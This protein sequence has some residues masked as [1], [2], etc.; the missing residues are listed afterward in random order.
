MSKQIAIIGAGLSGLLA[1]KYAMEKGFS[2]IVFE[3]KNGLGGVWSQTLKPTKLQTP[4]DYYQFSDFPWPDSVTGDFPHSNQVKDY[5]HSYA[6]HFNILPQIKFN[7]RVVDIDYVTPY[8]DHLHSWTCWGGTGEAFSAYG[9]WVV[10]VENHSAGP[11]PKTETYQVDFVVL[12]LGNFSDL[13]HIPDFPVNKGPEVF[14]GKVLHSM[15]YSAMDNDKAAEFINCK[16]VT[17]VGFQKS[18]I[19]IAAEVSTQNG[20]KHPCTLLFRRAHWVVPEL[21]LKLSFKYQNRFTEFM[22]HKPHEGFFLWLLSFLLY[23]LIWL[24]AVLFETVVKLKYP[25][26]RYKTIPDQNFI[27]QVSSCKAKVMPANFYKNA[28]EGSLIFKKAE[29]FHFCKNGLK[30]EGEKEPIETDIVIFATGYRTDDKLKSIFK[31]TYFQKRF[32]DSSAPFYRECIHPRIPQLAILGYSATPATLYTC[33]M[34]A[35]WLSHFLAGRFKL[36]AIKEMQADMM[37]W[38]KST[39]TFAKEDYKRA[40]VTAL[41]QIHNNDQLCKDMGVNPK[42]KS[43]FMPELFAPYTPADY[44]N[45]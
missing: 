40:C 35:R 3:A 11:L 21:L 18:A 32:V 20:V 42:R 4:R 25:L 31:S 33:E 17:V 36:P 39:Y 16:R 45:I 6:F 27:K 34:N 9:K 44:A 13:P 1:C 24:Y 2:P 15:D 26:R 37:E 10:T 5:L 22:L 38:K 7:S 28:N 12:C 14:R 23:P 29:N 19:D 41:L 43:W 8:E 30:V